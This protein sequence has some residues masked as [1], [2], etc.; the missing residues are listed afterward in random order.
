MRLTALSLGGHIGDAVA[1][2][3]ETR[4]LLDLVAGVAPATT[5]QALAALTKAGVTIT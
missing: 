4:L 2:G 5:E 3:F 1:A